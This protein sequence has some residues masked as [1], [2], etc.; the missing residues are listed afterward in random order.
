MSEL[1]DF[2]FEEAADRS[3]APDK[4]LSLRKAGGDAGCGTL[5]GLV[6]LALA[7]LGF[8]QPGLSFGRKLAEPFQH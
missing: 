4:A 2:P 1:H 3:L 8:Q 7:V 6:E 5:A